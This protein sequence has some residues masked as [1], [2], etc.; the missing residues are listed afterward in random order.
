MSPKSVALGIVVVALLA[1]A[2][3]GAYTVIQTKEKEEKKAAAD[4]PLCAETADR[5]KLTFE[6]PRATVQLNPKC[7]SGWVELPNDGPKFDGRITS[8]GDLEYLFIDGARRFVG[9]KESLWAGTIR[10]STFRLRGEGVA[11]ITIEPQ[12]PK[13]KGTT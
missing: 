2:A 11:T 7:W 13:K 12:A 3:G 5:A 8:P 9:G 4:Y 6:Q 1:V 10:N